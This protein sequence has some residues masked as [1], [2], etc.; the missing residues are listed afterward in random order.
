MSLYGAMITGVAGLSANSK[1]LGVA[2]SNIANVNTVGYK[3]SQSQ[4]STLLA[5]SSGAGDVSSAGVVAHATQNVSSQGLLTST[6]SA[7]DLAIQGNGFFV[8]S[9][10]SG[11]T[12]SL[13]YTRAG[14]FTPDEN[15]DLRNATG[16][17]LMGWPVD[18]NGTVPSDR[19]DLSAINVNN[20]AARP[21]PPPPWR[22]MPICRPARQLPP[23]T[24]QATWRPA[25]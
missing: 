7:T 12:Q 3:A 24:R 5:S 9:K 10:Q 14:N 8:T 25:R 23:V 17:Y 11:S 19:N 20:L 6:G 16:L 13:L 1:A 18:A 2:S 22:C 15:G 21:K 4:F